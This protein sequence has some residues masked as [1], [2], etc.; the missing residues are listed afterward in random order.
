MAEKQPAI[1]DDRQ[2]NFAPLFA[3]A[4]SGRPAD[5]RVDAETAFY[6]DFPEEFPRRFFVLMAADQPVARIGASVCRTDPDRGFIGFF[7]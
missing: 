3:V 7:A 4:G 2:E 5:G 6:L 1:I